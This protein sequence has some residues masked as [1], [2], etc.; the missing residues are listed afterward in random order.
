MIETIFISLNNMMESTPG[1]ALVASLTWGILSVL[2]SPCHL[3]G[4]PLIVGYISGEKELTTR[5][6]FLLSLLFATGILVTIGLV[7][8][9]TALLGR[10][11][12]DLGVLSQWIVAG[13]FVLVGLILMEVIPNPFKSPAQ[14]SIKSRGLWAALMLGLVFGLALGPCTFA[15]MA[16]VLILSFQVASQH[17]WLSILWYRALPGDRYRWDLHPLDSITI[18]L[19]RAIP[20]VVLVS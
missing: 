13:V 18:E 5:R 17:L 19:E 14:T 7:G 8:F 12:G 20:G 3:A 10:M 9:I 16:P 2:L 15:F 6:A 4:I 1:W 11:M